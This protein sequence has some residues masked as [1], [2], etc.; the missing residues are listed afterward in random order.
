MLGANFTICEVI[1]SWS[2]VGFA[3]TCTMRR[4]DLGLHV[5]SSKRFTTSFVVFVFPAVDTLLL[6]CAFVLVY[7]LVNDI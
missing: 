1:A 6:W 5:P 2:H 7:I 4:Y 3:V